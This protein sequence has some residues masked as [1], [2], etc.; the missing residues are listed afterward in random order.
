MDGLRVDTAESQLRLNGVVENYLQTPVVQV[1]TSGTLSMP[2]I[3]RIVP[4]VEPYGLHPKFDIKASGPAERLGL[5]LTVSTEAGNV[6]G[7]ITA[8]VEGPALGVEGQL[9]VERPQPGAGCS[10]T[11]RSAATSRGRPR[12]ISTSQERRRKRRSPSG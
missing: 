11:R 12:S 2:E 5:D 7:Q 3:G 9:S 1:T 8:D 10:R 4:A 6:A